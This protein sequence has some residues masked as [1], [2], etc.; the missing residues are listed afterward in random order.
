MPRRTALA[1]VLACTVYLLVLPTA[2]ATAAPSPWWQVLTG[3]HPT[4]LWK[5]APSVQE[6]TTE[7][8]EFGEVAAAI[9]IEVGGTLVGCLGTKNDIG[10]A[11]CEGGFGFPV[12]ETAGELEALLNAASGVGDIEVTGG[13]VG[14]NPFTVAASGASP[15]IGFIPAV[16]SAELKTI[17]LGGSGR[18]VLTL[19]NLGDAPVDA[20]KTPVTIT[21]ELPEGVIASR[22]EGF[23]G[24]LDLS[25]PVDCSVESDSLVSCTF[26]GMLPSYEGIEV[27]I[28]ASLTGD[29]PVAGA[30]GQV[31]V[32]GGNAKSVTSPQ[33]IEVSP[34]ETPFGIDHFSAE[35]EEEGGD[36]VHQAG[37]HPFQFTT[38]I[39]LNSGPLEAGPGRSGASIKQPALPRNLRFSL[40]AGLVGNATAVPRCKMDLFFEFNPVDNCPPETALGV[41]SATVIEDASLGLTRIAA[42]V[43][44]LPPAPGE[45]ARFG[46]SAKGVPVVVGTSVDPDDGY[47]IV[48]E[49]RNVTQLGDFLAGTVSIWVIPG[50][51]V[52]IVLVAGIALTGFPAKASILASAPVG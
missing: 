12:T 17:S 41:A 31:T 33:F 50:T 48:A 42:P 34:E 36:P 25:G 52:T 15:A 49:V 3:S 35:A 26:E 45:P 7:T 44:N 43:F 28:F 19:T 24:V 30:P 39:Q 23:A 20:T 10:T 11:V 4:N 22:V 1:A 21:D 14:G 32:S 18:L 9:G 6:I 5:P 40:P 16:G 8:A 47:R 46:F 13:P 37:S 27:E 29:P 51:L 38:T 2:A